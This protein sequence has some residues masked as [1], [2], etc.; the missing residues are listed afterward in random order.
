[1]GPSLIAA[2]G[3]AVKLAKLSITGESRPKGV[4]MKKWFYI[5]VSLAITCSA[6]QTPAIAAADLDPDEWTDKLGRGVLNFFTS[7]LEIPRN[8]SNTS[9]TKGAPTGWT[10]GLIKGFAK[11]IVRAGV[12]IIETLTFPFDFPDEDK[13]PLIQPEFA[14]QDWRE[15]V[16]TPEV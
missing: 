10:V 16:D 12:G 11:T 1:M 13:A 9:E 2:H 14:W 8:I 5:V 15:T 4:L 3:P 6:F 7:P